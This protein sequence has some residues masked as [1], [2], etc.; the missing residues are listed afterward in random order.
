[1]QGIA[2]G[3]MNVDFGNPLAVKY[4]QVALESFQRVSDIFEVTVVQCITP[5]TLLEGVNNDLSGRSP[6]ELAAFHSHYRAA[7]R[8]AKG[9]RIW[10]LEHDAF[11]RPECEDTFRMIMSK[12]SSKDSSLQLGM[13]NEFW[14][15]TPKIAA[16]NCKEFENGYKRGPMQLLH[17]VTDEY[18]RSKNNTHPNTYWPANRFKNPEYCNKTGLNV[19]V[20]SAYT[21]PLKIWDSPIIQIIDEE[22][23]GTVTDTGKRKYDREVHPDYSWITLD[24]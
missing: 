8:M 16:M 11:L 6:Q 21:K 22:F 3:I 24:K 23:G 12:W 5:D 4:M 7:K 2:R 10:M 19:D 14:T 20:S 18:C 9:E 13:A 17:V 1:M 15:T